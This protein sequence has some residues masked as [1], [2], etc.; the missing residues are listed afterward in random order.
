[1]FILKI[2]GS[3]RIPDYI[4]I[5]DAHFTLVAYFKANHFPNWL[6]KFQLQHQEMEINNLLSDLPYGKMINFPFEI[7][8]KN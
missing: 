5:R 3:S 8:N 2:K 7:N 1:M 6:K 4:Q